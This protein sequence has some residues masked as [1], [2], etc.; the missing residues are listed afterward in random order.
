MPP[1][2]GSGSPAP[3][4]AEVLGGVGGGEGGEG[5]GGTG[6]V[7]WADRDG[8]VPCGCRCRWAGR[9]RFAGC[10]CRACVG[11]GFEGLGVVTGATATGRGCEGTGAAAGVPDA[12]WPMAAIASTASASAP[13]PPAARRGQVRGSR[14][15]SRARC[16]SSS[17]SNSPANPTTSVWSPASR[18]SLPQRSSS[19]RH[20]ASV[21]YPAAAGSPGPLLE[22]WA[23]SGTTRGAQDRSQRALPVARPHQDRVD[24]RRAQ[25]RPLQEG[26]RAGPDSAVAEV[27]GVDRESRRRYPLGQ[28]AERQRQPRRRR[29]VPGGGWPATARCSCPATAPR[30]RNLR[31]SCSPKSSTPQIS[32]QASAHQRVTASVKASSSQPS[33]ANT[34]R[35]CAVRPDLVSSASIGPSGRARSAAGLA[36]YRP[37]ITSAVEVAESAMLRGYGRG[38]HGTRRNPSRNRHSSTRRSGGAWRLSRKAPSSSSLE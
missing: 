20:S 5:G 22:R 8:V 2:S 9:C 11:F 32:E 16:S 3:D 18:A 15:S 13:S 6:G 4:P 7:A 23:Q 25:Q 31:P 38:R 14:G 21:S 33:D 17:S 19:S 28:T 12:R 30:T 26:R 27:A 10:R 1:G 29:R 37:A 34:I 36:R 35:T 24:R